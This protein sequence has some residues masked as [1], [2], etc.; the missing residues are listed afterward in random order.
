MPDYPKTY[1]ADY[2]QRIIDAL[3]LKQL[4]KGEYHGQ[5]RK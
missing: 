5:E 2:G 3:D 4:S 1:W